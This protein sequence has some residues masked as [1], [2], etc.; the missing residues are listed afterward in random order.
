MLNNKGTIVI[1]TERLILRPFKKEDGA[2]M[3]KNWAND[4]RVTK[5]LRW[6]SHKNINESYD[7]CSIWEKESKNIDTY[8][9]AIELKETNEVIG[10]IGL[11]DLKEELL[12]G[13]IGYAIGYNYWGKGIVKEAL[14]DLIKYFK[15]IGIV[16]LQAYHEVP[17][18]NSGKVLIKCGFEYE[19]LLRKS[20]LNKD[21]ELV[22]AKIYS[23]IL[24]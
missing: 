24:N 18:I 5:Y 13:E 22:D 3:F 1:E 17:N 7:I 16:R 21:D 6:H 9:W 4:D 12:C 10:S 20:V 11:V 15:E 8:Q 19:G 23:I 14:I 2:N